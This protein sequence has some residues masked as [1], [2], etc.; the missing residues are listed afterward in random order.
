MK[1]AKHSGQGQA[2]GENRNAGQEAVRLSTGHV[3]LCS[4]GRGVSSCLWPISTWLGTRKRWKFLVYL[5]QRLSHSLH[6]HTDKADLLYVISHGPVIKTQAGFH[7]LYLVLRSLGLEQTVVLQCHKYILTAF[8]ILGILIT[9]Y[10]IYVIYTLR[11]WA[12]VY[13]FPHPSYLH[14]NA[15]SP[16]CWVLA[17]TLVA[18]PCKTI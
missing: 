7:F 15:F 2:C 6:A 4:Q 5:L 9:R 13:N 1:R 3:L 17:A 12:V 11:W 10:S 18:C 14:R 8:H 16:L